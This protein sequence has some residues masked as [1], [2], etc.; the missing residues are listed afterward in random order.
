[1]HHFYSAFGSTLISKAL[2]TTRSSTIMNEQPWFVGFWPRRPWKQA[3]HSIPMRT[4]NET[5]AGSTEDDCTLHLHTC[6][7][8][9]LFLSHRRNCGQTS[10]EHTTVTRLKST[11]LW[12]GH[13]WR[14]RQFNHC[15]TTVAGQAGARPLSTA[16]VG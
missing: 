15:L 5:S 16:T 9:S 10:S 7:S 12:K 11:D 3:A 2:N 6:L 4:C 1:M 13:M 8:P 14:E